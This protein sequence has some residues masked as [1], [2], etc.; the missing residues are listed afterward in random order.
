MKPYMKTILN[1]V[2]AWVRGEYKKSTD[3]DILDI[4]A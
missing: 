4:L 1:A 3:E 2:M